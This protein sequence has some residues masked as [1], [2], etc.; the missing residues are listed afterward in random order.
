MSNA[1]QKESKITRTKEEL[2][3]HNILIRSCKNYNG[4]DNSYYRAAVRTHEENSILIKSLMNIFEE[5][6]NK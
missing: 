1:R 5:Y 4:L 2:L 3:K 6:K